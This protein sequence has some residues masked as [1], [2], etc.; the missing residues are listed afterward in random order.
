MIRQTKKKAANQPGECFDKGRLSGT[1]QSDQTN[2]F[3]VANSPVDSQEYSPAPQFKG[4]SSLVLSILKLAFG[5]VAY[6]L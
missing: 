1:V 5:S 6:N 3:M 2:D 4:I